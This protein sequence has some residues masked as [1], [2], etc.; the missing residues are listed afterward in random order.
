MW[1]DDT[2]YAVIRGRDAR[3]DGQFFTGVLTTGIYCRPSCPA[4]TPA[5]KNVRFF[6]TAAAAQA[7]GFRSC[8]RCRPEATPGSPSWDVTGDV[9]ARA[10]GL[11]D[12]GIVDRE[13][14][15]GLS[16]RLGYSRRQLQRILVD[17]VGAAPLALATAHRLHT[18]RALL[19]HTT[20]A[21][22]E[23]AHA[24][25]FG[26]V[27]QFNEAAQAGWGLTPTQVRDGRRGSAA[28][29]DVHPPPDPARS[30]LSA[31]RAVSLELRLRVRTPFDGH[32]LLA[33]LAARAVPGLE[34]AESR[35]HT[36]TLRLH[37]GPA[38]VTLTPDESEVRARVTL[39]DPRDLGAT[40]ARCRA[41]LDL[42]ADPEAVAEVLRAD[43]ALAPLV[44][45]AP[46][47]RVPG[48]AD[49]FETLLRAVIGQQVSVAGAA[50]TFGAIVDRWGARAPAWAGE[51]WRMLPEPET[52]TEIDPHVGLMPASRWSA[53]IAVARGVAAGEIDVSPGADRSAVRRVL[54][55]IRGI[56]D[57]TVDYV[58]LR[59]YADPDAFPATDLVLRKVTGI[60]A[61]ELSRRAE[62]WRPWRAYAAQHLWSASA[63]GR[64]YVYEE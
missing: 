62:R 26:S 13:G 21:M 23:V 1:D 49:R 41:M 53:V 37:H 7:E 22:V 64:G 51:G 24:S 20:L 5:R 15:D 48:T 25:G 33:F 12:D 63:E 16:S 60:G 30:K 27:R 45:E 57:W 9:A 6:R 19:E 11:I 58:M 42:D 34:R 10:M 46:G 8:R 47:L 38:I 14:V 17:E 54:R 28:R 32:R 39:S 52:L 4:R 59:A 43:A 29:T 44:A 61:A 55:G 3:Y 40:V 18:A 31:E 2:R 56:G 36:R 35:S 50:T